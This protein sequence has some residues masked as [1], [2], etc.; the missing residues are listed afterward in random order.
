MALANSCESYRDRIRIEAEPIWNEAGF[1][2]QPMDGRKAIEP[3]A[4]DKAS[5]SSSS[6]IF[7]RGAITSG[8]ACMHASVLQVHKSETEL[9]ASRI[10]ACEYSSAPAECPGPRVGPRQ[11]TPSR[12][13]W[14]CSAGWLPRLIQA[15]CRTLLIH[16][17]SST[18]SWVSQFDNNALALVISSNC[19]IVVG[20]YDQSL[21]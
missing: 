9:V 17:T 10:V 13:L 8:G 20:M 7:M 5:P 1:D 19:R 11:V 18:P 21:N 4:T 6:R 12:S 15:A 3:P 14:A 16:G 2:L